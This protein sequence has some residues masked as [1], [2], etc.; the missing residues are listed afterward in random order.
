MIVQDVMT[1]NVVTCMPDTD[2]AAAATAMRDRNCGFL[3]VVDSHGVIRGV[4][5]DRDLC[6][7]AA[8]ARRSPARVC[9]GEVMSHPVFACFPEDN[10]KTVLASMS[11]HHVRRMPVLDKEHGHLQGV[12]SLDDI[13]LAPRRRGAP[14]SEEIVATMRTIYARPQTLSA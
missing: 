10:L 3:P 1:R 14:T 2:L 4:L 7:L 13:V 9:A 5:T 12:L 8:T 11:K 6:I